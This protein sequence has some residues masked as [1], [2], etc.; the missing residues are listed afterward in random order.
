MWSSNCD[1]YG[2]DFKNQMSRREDCGDLCDKNEVCTHFSWLPPSGYGLG[3]CLLKNIGDNPLAT[4]NNNVL[5]G[6]V[7]RQSASRLF[8][9]HSFGSARWSLNCGFN[10]SDVGNQKS[11]STDCATLCEERGWVCQLF[12]SKSI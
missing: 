6:Y 5:C 11:S 2:G 4:V 3:V 8:D 9:F 12:I 10:G 7:V 1:F